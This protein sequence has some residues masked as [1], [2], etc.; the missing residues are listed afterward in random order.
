MPVWLRFLF[1]WFITP[2]YHYNS[3]RLRWIRWRIGSMM[4]TR[5]FRSEVDE[6]LE[7]LVCKVHQ[8]LRFIIAKQ[9]E[10]LVKQWPLTEVGLMTFLH[11]YSAFHSS[12]IHRLLQ[13]SDHLFV[14]LGSKIINNYIESIA[15]R[16]ETTK[17]LFCSLSRFKAEK[18]TDSGNVATTF[19][20]G[21]L[22]QKDSL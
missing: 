9:Q 12:V 14:L 7:R 2:R 22:R 1:I 13:I 4:L 6:R 18:E 16:F 3:M 20:H 5:S 21:D 15:D 11:L 17:T 19:K 10:C 8:L